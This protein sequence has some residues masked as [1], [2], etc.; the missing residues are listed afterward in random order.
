[1]A[2]SSDAASNPILSA[3]AKAAGLD[4]ST[5]QGLADLRTT[6][7]YGSGPIL[8]VEKLVWSAGPNKR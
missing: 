5:P 1:M 4:I 6:L 8:T 3:L 2:N 7:S